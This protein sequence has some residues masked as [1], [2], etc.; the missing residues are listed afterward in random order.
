ME[1][2]PYKSVKKI[3]AQTGWISVWGSDSPT[4]EILKIII[5]SNTPNDVK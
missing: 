5:F 3:V 4:T 2:S 1:Q